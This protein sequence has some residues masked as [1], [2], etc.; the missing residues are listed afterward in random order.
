MPARAGARVRTVVRVVSAAEAA[1]RDSAAIAAGTPSRALMQRAGAAAAS[2]ISRRFTERL[3]GGALVYAGPGNNGGDAWVVAR[4]LAASGIPVWVNQAG[5]TR[6]GDALL[7]RELA[8]PFVQTGG[9]L[10]GTLIVDGLLGTGAHGEPRGAIAA[11]ISDINARHERGAIVVALDTPSGVHATTGNACHAVAADVTLTFG[12]LKR[13]LLIARLQAGLIAVLDI[14]LGDSG[15]DD[16]APQLATSAWVRA[17]VPAIRADAHKGSRKKLAIIGGAVGMAGAPVLAA[18]AAMRSGMGM[19]KLVVAPENVPVVQ[20]AEPCALASEWPQSAE[21][22]PDTVLGWAD[23][24]L[25][26]PGLGDTPLSRDLVERVLRSWRG[27]VVIDADALNVFKG[28]ME[29]LSGLLNGRR[30]LLTPH[31]AEVSRLTGKPVEEVLARRF[32]IGGE[33]ARATGAAVLLKGVPTIVTG[34]DGARLVSA[35]GTPALAVAGSGDVLAGIAATLLAQIDDAAAAGACAAFVHGRA[36]ELAG[37]GRA[38][39]G[40]ALDD[41]IGSLGDAWNFSEADP[42]YPVIAELPAVAGLR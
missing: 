26:G 21:S 14:G 8:I 20:G 6:A 34:A 38:V 15:D 13:G 17:T 3:Q 19:V 27:P 29:A 18:R 23:A 16:D 7:E 12:T 41:V 25:L 4:A 1:H 36:A 30:A 32:E 35:R 33:I 9:P 10:E 2:E 37:R 22:L 42:V 24:V 39:R 28:N 31:P 5:E 11:A 40:V